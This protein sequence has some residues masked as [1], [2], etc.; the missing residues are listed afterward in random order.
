[1]SISQAVDVMVERLDGSNP[2]IVPQFTD[3]WILSDSVPALNTTLYTPKSGKLQVTIKAIDS[4]QSQS[5]Y[6][7]IIPI[8]TFINKGDL[9]PQNFTGI[10]EDEVLTIKT[11]LSYED[12]ENW[13]FNSTSHLLSFYFYLKELETLYDEVLVPFKNSDT[14]QSLLSLTFQIKKQLEKDVLA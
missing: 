10:S 1:M 4:A 6:S 12:G 9:S 13:Q 5:V 7:E 2:I 8:T 14:V 3:D 11:Y